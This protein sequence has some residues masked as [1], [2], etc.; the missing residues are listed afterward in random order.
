LD[1]SSQRC[2]ADDISPHVARGWTVFD[3]LA[4]QQ[5]TQFGFFF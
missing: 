4:Q 3:Q 5:V 1:Q 2:S